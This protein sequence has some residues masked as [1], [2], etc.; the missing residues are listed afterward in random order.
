MDWPEYKR[1]CDR[2]DYWSHWMLNQC[3]ELIKHQ[4][5]TG[6]QEAIQAALVNEP[7][8]RPAD[9]AGPQ[10]TFMYKFS[11]SLSLSELLLAEI[12]KAQKT[13]I[14]TVATRERGLAGFLAACRELVQFAQAEAKAASTLAN[15][16]AGE[17]KDHV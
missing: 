11:P 3:L 17:A 12:E 8:H 9:H 5:S 13:N 14:T 16:S 2:P 1:L 10:S 6:L 7:L 4:G 15:S